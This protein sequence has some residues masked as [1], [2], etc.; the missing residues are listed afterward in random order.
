[1]GKTRGDCKG[2]VE[3]STSTSLQLSNVWPLN[4][5]VL[6]NNVSR[7]GAEFAEKIVTQAFITPRTLHL[8]GK[9]S[10]SVAWI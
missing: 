9:L 10:F 6:N 3:T 7:R 8:C 4:P 2:F 5:P 1:M